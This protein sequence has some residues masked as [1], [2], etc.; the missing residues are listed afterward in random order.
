M[1]FFRKLKKDIGLEENSQGGA[2][3]TE[4]E[5]EK[6]ES[7]SV[8]VKEQ[9]PEKEKPKKISSDWLSSEGQLAVD[10]Y[11]TPSDF[12]VQAPIAG[13]G[14]EE[15]EVFVE[16][17]TLVIKGERKKPE[18]NKEKNYFYQE[19]YWG[20]FSRR[21]ILPEDIDTQKIKAILQKGI[22]TIKI[23]RAKKIKKRKIT[24]VSE[25]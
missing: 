7:F 6:K 19:C 25:E 11:Q 17:D 14:V 16:N 9:K 22:L 2:E 10:V 4:K 15:I 18:P 20:P 5:P 24:V 3:S 21:I 13:V 23:P 8:E 12:C 1:S